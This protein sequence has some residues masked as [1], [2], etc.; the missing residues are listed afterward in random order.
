MSC[1]EVMEWC[2]VTLS[3]EMQPIMVPSLTSGN[4]NPSIR[5]NPLLCT[6]CDVQAYHNKNVYRRYA[7]QYM[8]SYLHWY[9]ENLVSQTKWLDQDNEIMLLPS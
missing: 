9:A 8:D 5:S 4:T 1:S 7:A 6:V 3:Y 2:N